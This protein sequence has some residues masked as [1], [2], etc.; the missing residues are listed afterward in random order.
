M[1][2][3]FQ[4]KVALSI[5]VFIFIN[6][7]ITNSVAAL[8]TNYITSTEGFN[9]RLDGDTTNR[10]LGWPETYLADINGNGKGDLIVS[11][12][13]NYVYVIFDNIL[14]DNY[15]KG[16]T[17]TASG[18]NFSFRISGA[19]W[20]KTADVTGDG[21]NEL[22]LHKNNASSS[23]KS[24]NGEVY[25]YQTEAI[26]QIARGSTISLN[27]AN[28]YQY[29]IQG[30]D[31][32]DALGYAVENFDIN[33][34]GVDDLAVSAT[35]TDY[36]G[37]NNGSIYI[38]Y[39]SI[40]SNDSVGNVITLSDADPSTFS[41]RI[42]GEV[43]GKGIG[44]P[45]AN[46]FNDD[47]DVDLVVSCGSC[48]SEGYTNAG[49]VYVINGNKIADSGTGNILPL[50]T[51]TNYN[52]K[53]GGTG[54][55][56]FIRTTPQHG[57]VGTAT[58]PGLLIQRYLLSGELISSNITTTG[59]TLNLTSSSAYTVAFSGAQAFTFNGILD[60]DNDGYNDYVV[61]DIYD[62]TTGT[63]KGATYF[64][65][66]QEI[67]SLSGVGN[68]LN[69]T[70][71]DVSTF[72][73]YG[74]PNSLVQSQSLI[75]ATDGNNDG[76][77]DFTFASDWTAYQGSRS[78]SAWILYNFPHTITLNETEN[79]SE[80]DSNITGSVNASNSVSTVANV[81]W[82][83]TN[84]FSGTWTDCS[85][86]DG[87]F[88]S[89]EELFTCSVSTTEEGDK[90][91]FVR[92][93]DENSVYTPVSGYT[94]LGAVIDT[95]GPDDFKFSL[96]KSGKKVKPGA[97]EVINVIE[98]KLTFRFKVN[99]DGS[100]IDKVKISEH[101]DFRGSK[102]KDYEDKMSFKLSE[103]DE[104]KTVY[105]RLK[106]DAGNTSKTYKQTFKLDT[107][108]PEFTLDNVSGI[109]INLSNYSTFYYEGNYL[110]LT[111]TCENTVKV[112]INSNEPAKEA[113]CENEE[114][115]L[116]A[117]IVP[118]GSNVVEVY[119]KDENSNESLIK[120]TLVADSSRK[121]FP[122]NLR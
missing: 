55:N 2:M 120:F 46:D 114:W 4:I 35:G 98:R 73:I 59:N 76:S 92:A 37:A 54:A 49:V 38:F 6:L 70:S 36:T 101:K 39:D 91:I 45:S 93:V 15:G 22:I 95:T 19:Y 69:I 13:S 94:Q 106:D 74:D 75:E 107:T 14:E 121:L 50:T 104:K 85:A 66:G 97:K 80:E 88:D 60:F 47:G 65:K 18:T 21:V 33:G 110:Y 1:Y 61:S 86:T 100:G 32:S 62:D 23:G 58:K 116:S 102:W 24:S 7:A 40:F 57:L 108:A 3:S 53:I 79:L 16:E 96:T 64:I 113:A 117:V 77:I 99:E 109:P 90:N 63:N 48:T 84:T 26:S 5:F 72:V 51:T 12:T 29:V 67:S 43:A 25:I 122:A 31:S 115:L 56:A 68:S 41:V 52:L 105:F 34:N 111:G 83:F 87:T 118:T 9:F 20:F 27:D 44:Y 78:G 103:G 119:S 89:Y 28:Y 42:D 10:Y 11:A 17:L 71:S 82:S 81:Q 112:R 8:N 30:A